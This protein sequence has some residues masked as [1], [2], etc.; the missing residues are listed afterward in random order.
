[1]GEGDGGRTCPAAP[2]PTQT[3]HAP[4]FSTNQPPQTTDKMKFRVRTEGGAQWTL[5]ADEESEEEGRKWVEAIASAVARWVL[6]LGIWSLCLIGRA[7]EALIAM[8]WSGCVGRL[9]SRCHRRF[10]RL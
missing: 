7:R 3:S 4:T 6:V 8:A 9:L 1:M 5:A 10:T 2:I